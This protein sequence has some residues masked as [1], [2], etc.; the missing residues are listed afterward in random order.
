[1]IECDLLDYY[2]SL[3]QTHILVN[4]IV[5]AVFRVGEWPFNF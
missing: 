3:K 4:I 1:M 5:K 2:M